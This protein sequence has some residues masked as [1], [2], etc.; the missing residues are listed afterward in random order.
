MHAWKRPK[1]NIPKTKGEWVWDVLGYTAYIGSIIL[2]I[3]V[4]SQLP[5]KIPAHF[6][7]AGEVDRWGSK[8]ELLILP[9][10]GAFTALMLQVF[11]KYPEWHNYPKRFNETNAEKFYL[12]SR[13]LLNQVKNICFILFGLLLF[14]SIS[15]A[16]EWREGFGVWFLP[17][18]L[19]AVFFPMGLGIYKQR[20]IK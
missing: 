19:I 4:W 5:E 3:I 14:E 7:G 9:M 12:H 18:I 6:N 10:V 13:K 16:L 8:G 15:I 1:V 2:L 11:E 17:S 20:R